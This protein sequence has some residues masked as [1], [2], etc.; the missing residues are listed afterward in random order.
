MDTPTRGGVVLLLGAPGVGKSTLGRYLQH[1][2]PTTTRFLSVGDEL[3]AK[4]LVGA[5][6]RPGAEVQRE[7]RRLARE[8]LQR[9][10]AEWAAASN[11]RP[12]PSTAP[13]RAAAPI[14]VLEAVKEVEDAFTV[15]KLLREADVPLLQAL[16][17]PGCIVGNNTLCSF[18]ARSARKK[19]CSA[20]RD[21]ERCVAERQGKWVAN[22]GRVIEFFSALGVLTEVS[23][24]GYGNTGLAELGYRAGP[25]YAG[26]DDPSDG[27]NSPGHSVRQR[28]TD[29]LRASLTAA[30]TAAEPPE[31]LRVTGWQLP[32]DL[33][34]TP[35]ECVTSR[36]LVTSA[37][38]RNW[39]LAEARSV[40]GGL[41]VFDS[42]FR[43]GDKVFSAPSLSV[44]TASVS[45]AEDVR[46]AAAAAPGA[47]STRSPSLQS[48]GP[49]LLP[50]SVLDGELVWLGGRG[51][52]L[53]FDAL[54]VGGEP[55]WQ[56]PLRE[57]LAALEQRLGL[58]EAEE[59]LALQQAAAAAASTAAAATALN[60]AA[61]ATATAKSRSYLASAAA[62]DSGNPPR[63]LLKKQQAA[64]LGSDTL[65]ILRKRHVPV[66]Y[67][68]LRDLGRGSTCPYPTD[69]LV[70][71]PYSMPYV[72]GMAELLYKW[73]PQG[74]VA[75]DIIGSDLSMENL[76]WRGCKELV[77][78]CLWQQ[79]PER[80]RVSRLIMPVSVRWDK[81]YGN[82]QRA[83]EALKA[84]SGD[85]SLA[86]LL[87]HL[88]EERGLY[89]RVMAAVTSGCVER[90]VEPESGLEIFNYRSGAVLGSVE[91]MCRG[92]VLHPPSNTVVAAPFV[93][94]SE[95]PPLHLRGVAVHS[96]AG[97][98]EAHPRPRPDYWRRAYRERLRLPARTLLPYGYNLAGL[99]GWGQE[100]MVAQVKVDGSLVL[101]FK[102]AGQ[103]RTATRRRMDSEQALWAAEW[104]Q[105]HAD[106]AAF[107]PGWTYML[108]AVYGNNTVIVPYTFDG[109][110][111]LGATDPR[112]AEVPLA[113]LPRLAAELRVTTAVPYITGPLSQLLTNLPGLRPHDQGTA[114]YNSG[115]TPP[116][117][118]AFEGW[119]IATAD[120]GTP[121]QKLVQLSYKRACLAGKLLHPLSVWDLIR[122]GGASRKS[123]FLGLPVH[124][125]RELA[126]ILEA[127]EAGYQRARN[128][129]LLLLERHRGPQQGQ[130]QRQ[131]PPPP[132]HRA[133]G[134]SRSQGTKF[135]GNGG[136]P[137][138][139]ESASATGT[140]AGTRALPAALYDRVMA[141]VTSGCV[142]RT[143]E[144]ESGLEIF[145]YR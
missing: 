143:V 85:L 86:S 118:P 38:E 102:W 104:L 125:Q 66:S 15:V 51:F 127:L 94:F 92:L 58:T 122:N 59:S 54:C 101:A 141:A 21:K 56:L 1:R 106:P 74:S 114:T 130:P 137:R 30:C 13:H 14:L 45:T 50:G 119:I 90:T 20:Q 33:E 44:P 117:A 43:D 67:E 97:V 140:A 136:R 65:T 121:R 64:P 17:L 4:G 82:S 116:P 99:D 53:A 62:I 61:I 87:T 34:V 111:L 113:E 3:R 48:P 77:Y 81:V 110:V 47:A 98:T 8:L 72:L 55:L 10:I 35:L 133:Q 76:A 36:R 19:Q 103:L 108:E 109:L 2:H 96:Q 37:E 28:G 95:V 112:G 6:Q 124:F 63:L 71:T 39:V 144:P 107:K 73:Q 139:M 84:G 7:V 52:F 26:K 89:D 41:R 29:F 23:S 120:G 79:R 145:N 138:G 129:L 9:E 31:W 32:W 69:G 68:A 80:D 142:E 49:A 57:R 123:L 18:M 75:V 5:R 70:F 88:H 11:A 91:A 78:E 105:T 134:A 42:D 46:V 83:I 126:A 16:Y 25:T 27:A 24:P 135:S 93:K 22:A 60:A 40:S 128:Q 115:D 131:E 100:P 132:P 12:G